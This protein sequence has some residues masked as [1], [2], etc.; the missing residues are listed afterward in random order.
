MTKEP[1]TDEIIIMGK[2]DCD[3][4]KQGRKEWYWISGWGI[5]S[6]GGGG[7]HFGGHLG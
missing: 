5:G 2:F 1:L 3:K 6:V 7:V 4:V